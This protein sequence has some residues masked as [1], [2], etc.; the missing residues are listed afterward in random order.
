M[1]TGTDQIINR[2]K[3]LEKGSVFTPKDLLDLASRGLIDVT[4]RRLASEGV[5]RKLGR[6]L[7]DYP[8]I[9]SLLKTPLSPDIDQVAQALARRFRW[10][11]V[12]SGAHAANLLGLS[13]QVPAKAVYL[14]DGPAKN[15]KIGNRELVFKKTR[16]RDMGGTEDSASALIIQALKHLGKDAV[17]SDTIRELRARLPKSARRNFLLDA[18]YASD[19]IFDLAKKI[20]ENNEGG[21]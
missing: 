17:T 2:I 14:T 6:G 12:P 1:S 4:L 8:K 7:Y 16:P 9:S 3:G 11:I 18:R 5:I 21:E 13:T 10:R 15:L 19:W 20:A